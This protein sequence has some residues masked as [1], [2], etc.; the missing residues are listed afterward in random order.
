MQAKSK[1]YQRQ[2]Q[3][4]A[5]NQKQTG[6]DPNLKSMRKASMLNFGQLKKNRGLAAIKNLS[7]RTTNNHIRLCNKR[8]D[9]IEKSLKRSESRTLL[10]LKI[11]RHVT[12]GLIILSD[13]YPSK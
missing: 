4:Q 6:H 9:N 5:D 1:A 3:K 11:A 2:I 7:I 10:N 13:R 8:L 12:N